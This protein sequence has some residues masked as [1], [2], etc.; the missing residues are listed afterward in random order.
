[1]LS[2]GLVMVGCGPTA[3]PAPDLSAP[4][5]ATYSINIADVTAD[6]KDVATKLAEIARRCWQNKVPAFEG[7]KLAEVKAD[8]GRVEFK[9]VDPAKP[10]HLL[11]TVNGPG[12]TGGAGL[13][14]GIDQQ[15]VPNAQPY[16]IG[17]VDQITRRP[18]SSCPKPNMAFS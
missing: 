15:D 16:I 13:T 2:L 17:A 7:L 12:A 1:M 6:P 5:P 11:V 10:K 14:I 8:A 9:S 4:K 3:R 18:Q